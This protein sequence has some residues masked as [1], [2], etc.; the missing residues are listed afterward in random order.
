MIQQQITQFTQSLQNIAAD[1]SDPRII[2]QHMPVLKDYPFIQESPEYLLYGLGG[3]MVLLFLRKRMKKNK[4]LKQSNIAMIMPKPYQADQDEAVSMDDLQN[5]D[6]ESDGFDK[7]LLRQRVEDNSGERL[8]IRK[9]KTAKK[10]EAPEPQPRRRAEPAPRTAEQQLADVSAMNF[11]AKPA[12]TP[13]EARMRVLVQAVLNEF[14]AG[15]MIMARTALGAIIEPA[16]EAVGPERAKALSAVEGK[17]LDFGV[18]D[19][20]GRCLLALDVAGATP[21]LG[22]KAAERQVVQKALS[23]AGLPLAN[24]TSKDTPADVRSKI[25]PYLQPGAQARKLGT[26]AGQSERRNA[27]ENNIRPGRPKRPVRAAHAA[28]IA[29]E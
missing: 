6:L 24:L 1:Y 23:N 19:R 27:R 25:A 29:A 5:T 2:L 15:Y 14:G 26:P 17:F 3:I 13:D 18:F 7:D 9:P 10:A 16:R 21:A 8:R 11:A 12:M 4:K 28:A 20:A 22:N